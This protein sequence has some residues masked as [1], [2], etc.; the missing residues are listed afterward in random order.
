MKIVISCK[1]TQVDFS[2]IQNSGRN[3][4]IF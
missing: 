2:S 3:K 4:K 1:Y